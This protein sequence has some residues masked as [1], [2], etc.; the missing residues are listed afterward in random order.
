MSA[1]TIVG[2]ALKASWRCL[3]LDYRPRVKLC[4]TLWSRFPTLCGEEMDEVA[5]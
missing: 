5:S 2:V 1:Q 4:W 3:I